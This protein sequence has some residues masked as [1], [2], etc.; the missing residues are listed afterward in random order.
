M[1]LATAGAARVGGSGFDA[2]KS[3]QFHPANILT[4]ASFSPPPPKS[5]WQRLI[6]F[7]NRRIQP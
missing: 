4:G 3:I 6:E 1:Q 2:F 5:P 7:L